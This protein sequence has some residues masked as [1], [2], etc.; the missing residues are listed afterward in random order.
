MANLDLRKRELGLEVAKLLDRPMPAPLAAPLKLTQ[1]C[2]A[3]VLAETLQDVF[4]RG[5]HEVLEVTAK[6]GREPAV[7]D[8]R[9]FVSPPTKLCRYLRHRAPSLLLGGE[10]HE[11]KPPLCWVLAADVREAEEVEGLD[12]TA[13]L[14]APLTRES[15]ASV[16][17]LLHPESSES[18]DYGARVDPR[19]PWLIVTDGKA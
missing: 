7:R 5:C 3:D 9:V 18:P 17:Q 4:V 11:L 12:L 15:P 13:E 2:V 6:H 1:P 10:P 8:A 19:A 16:P 14:R